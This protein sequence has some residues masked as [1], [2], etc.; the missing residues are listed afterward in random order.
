MIKTRT[1]IILFCIIF[2]LILGVTLFLYC[3]PKE[4]PI[5]RIYIDG[6]CVQSIDLSAAEDG[7]YEIETPYGTNTVSIADHK[8]CVSQ[9]DCPNHTCIKTGWISDSTMPIVC[10][11]HRL[12]IKIDSAKSTADAVTR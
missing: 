10:L 6:N 8:I 9:S 12:V 4:N 2:A 5:A 7:Y 1:W 11:P 3:A